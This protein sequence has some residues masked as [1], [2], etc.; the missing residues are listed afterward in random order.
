MYLASISWYFRKSPGIHPIY[1][2]CPNCPV[3]SRKIENAVFSEFTLAL[4]NQMGWLSSWAFGSEHFRNSNFFF[5]PGVHGPPGPGSDRYEIF[6]SLLVLVRSEIWTFLSVLIRSQVF[7]FSPNTGTARS[8]YPCCSHWISGRI[9]WIFICSTWRV[10]VYSYNRS[11]DLTG[12]ETVWK[13]FWWILLW[14]SYLI[15]VF[16]ENK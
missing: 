2:F 14:I 10:N 7:K 15:K 3:S 16:D 4:A 6:K 5:S 9:Y 13:M 12:R 11:D 8:V 1:V